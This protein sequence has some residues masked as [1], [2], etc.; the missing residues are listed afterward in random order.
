MN[1]TGPIGEEARG[2]WTKIVFKQGR[3]INI[4]NIIGIKDTGTWSE[5]YDARGIT[6]KVNL[7]E[8]NYIKIN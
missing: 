1:C 4:F 8:V 6:Y 2:K 7:A 3:E 5:Y